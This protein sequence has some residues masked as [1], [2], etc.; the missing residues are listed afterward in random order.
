MIRF[1][2]I[3]RK[4]WRDRFFT[5]LKIL[6]LAIGIATCLVVFKIVHYEFS[7]D[8]KQPGKEDIY[9][10]VIRN[11]DKGKE[12]GF[13]GIQLPLAAY[14]KD[15]LPDI[16]QVVPVNNVR[17]EN[18]EVERKDGEIYRKEDPWDIQRTVPEYFEMVPYHWLAG[19]KN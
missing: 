2:F 12:Y 10:V 19:D 14:V 4:L 15:E 6:G 13:G 11:V 7:F 17:F 8:K 18:L 16:A 3:F 5:F 9:Q 1:K